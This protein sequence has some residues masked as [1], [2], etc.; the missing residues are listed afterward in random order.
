VKRSPRS[1]LIAAGLYLVAMLPALVMDNGY[2]PHPRA[3]LLE[4]RLASPARLVADAIL[5]VAAFVPLG[6]LLA[7]GI[8]D[9]AASPRARR[10]AVVGFCAVVSLGVE[11]LQY[12]LPSRYSSLVDVL[13]NSAGALVGALLA[14]R[15]SS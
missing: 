11:T 5:N 14:E 8:R 3:F 15:L 13:A 6:W 9:V 2:R 10:L 12:F 7:Q 1:S 4:F